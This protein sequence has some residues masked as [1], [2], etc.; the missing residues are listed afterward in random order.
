VVWIL[1]EVIPEAKVFYGSTIDK[2]PWRLWVENV[3]DLSEDLLNSCELCE[4]ENLH[5]IDA[6]K[7]IIKRIKGFPH[8]R[9]FGTS[10]NY[11]RYFRDGFIPTP[12]SRP[13]CTYRTHGSWPNSSSGMWTYPHTGNIYN[14]QNTMTL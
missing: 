14:G 10:F 8:C 5:S 13:A 11:V 2:G 1:R 7:R 3:T 6:R 4:M 9:D 12:S